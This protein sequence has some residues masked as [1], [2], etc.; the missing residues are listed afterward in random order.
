MCAK[1]RTLPVFNMPTRS[2]AEIQLKKL[3]EKYGKTVPDLS[4]WLENELPEDFTVFNVKPDS[5]NACQK[6]RTTNMVEFQNKE[7]KKRI[8]YIR[9]FLRNLYS[10]SQRRSWSNWTKNVL[11]MG[12]S[13]WKVDCRDSENLQKKRYVATGIYRMVCDVELE[14]THIFRYKILSLACLPF[15]QPRIKITFM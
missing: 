15:H 13:I 4:S 5:L 2:D 1:L 14:P 11:P 10:E 7:L 9:V 12:R 6:L 8:R 3:I